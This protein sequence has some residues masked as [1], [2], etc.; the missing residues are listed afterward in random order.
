MLSNTFKA[1]GVKT[2]LREGSASPLCGR[3]ANDGEAGQWEAFQCWQQQRS[4][5]LLVHR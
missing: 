5:R 3:F 4:L 1:V 2:Y